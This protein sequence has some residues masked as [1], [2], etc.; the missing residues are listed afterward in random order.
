M[1]AGQTLWTRDELLLAINLYAKIPFG[2]MDQRTKE[3]QELARIINRSPS[4]VARRL[5]NFASMDPVHIARGILGLTNSGNLAIQVW[6]EFHSNW[7]KYFEISE[8][9]LAQYKKVKVEQ[10]YNVNLD[11][12]EK[13]LEKERL[14]KT[15]LNQYR[16]RELVMTN[17][18]YTCCITGIQQPELLIASHIISWSSDQNNRLNPANGL[19]LNALHDK[20]FDKGL[21]TINADDST[22]LVSSLLKKRHKSNAVDYFLSFEGKKIIP[23]K[24]FLPNPEFLRSHNRL[25]QQRTKAV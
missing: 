9:L 14:V 2:K 23:P 18:N 8:S 19:C 4:A 21:I 5:A 6:N 20:A 22:I 13:G 3:V 11:E 17:Y 7:D 16:F 15:R 10:L 25:F 12:L 24:K 1:K